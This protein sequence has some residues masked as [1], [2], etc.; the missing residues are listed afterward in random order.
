VNKKVH[1]EAICCKTILLIMLLLC[2]CW[3]AAA[4]EI[5]GTIV[6][7]LRIRAVPEYPR[8]TVTFLNN[9]TNVVVRTVTTDERGDYTVPLLPIGHYTINCAGKRF[10]QGSG[11]KLR[12]KC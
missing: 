2:S 7:Q 8:P 11:Q 1:A 12:A 6:A 9:D 4:A 3:Y 5:T 10:Q